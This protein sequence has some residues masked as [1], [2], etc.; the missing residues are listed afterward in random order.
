M[1]LKSN[2]LKLSAVV[3]LID[4]YAGRPIVAGDVEFYLDGIR[5]LPLS[6]GQGIYAFVGL[7]KSHYELLV[8]VDGYF[9]L[10]FTLDAL[11]KNNVS[12]ECTVK[13]LLPAPTYTYPSGITMLRGLVVGESQKPLAG[14]R[15]T[16]D[17]ATARG[18]PRSSYTF[19]ADT[20]RYD[21]R[22]ALPV[23]GKIS[24]ASEVGFQFSKTGYASIA[25][26]VAIIVGITQFLDVELKP[27]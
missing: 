20:G 17:Y 5:A 3:Q 21:G 1:S 27:N 25:K 2:T 15:V 13:L 12:E 4:S 11:N 22:F 14:V 8:K 24:A 19:T 9:P 23:P 26:R 7:D 18:A 16:S 10:T 6:K